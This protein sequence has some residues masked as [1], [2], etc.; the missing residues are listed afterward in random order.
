MSKSDIY[1]VDYALNPYF[2]CAHGCVYCYARFT[3][4]LRDMDPDLWG[5]VVFPKINTPGLLLREVR[6]KRRGRVLVSSVTDPYQYIEEEYGLTR[7]SLEILA[8]NNWPVIILTKS[9]LVLR[10][11]DILR[12][13]PYIEVGLTVTIVEDEYREVFEPRAPS[14]SRRINALRSLIKKL[15]RDRV[16]A[17]FGPL[18]PIIGEKNIENIMSDLHD[19][20]VGR[21]IFDKLNI[22]SRNWE[23]INR[24]LDQIGVD[25]RVFWVKTKSMSFWGHIKRRIERLAAKYHIPIDFCY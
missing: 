9:D 4:I 3:F 15:G 11:L 25:K 17:F 7:R 2:G 6:S 23:T 22:K 19:I 12:R 24:A 16:Y 18:I 14:Y 21:I 13:F 20:G 8:K 5:R 10:D 1:G